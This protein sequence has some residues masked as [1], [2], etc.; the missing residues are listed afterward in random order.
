LVVLQ[1]PTDFVDVQG[2]STEISP[3]SSHGA[4]EAISIKAEVLSGVEEEEDPLAM[5]FPVIKAEPEVSVS[6]VSMLG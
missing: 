2:L 1:D 3:A 4:Y 6:L 5:T